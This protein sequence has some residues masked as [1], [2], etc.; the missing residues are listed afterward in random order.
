MEN[1]P[2]LAMTGTASQPVV[3]DILIEGE[4]KEEDDG[5]PLFLQ[6]VTEEKNLTFQLI[7]VL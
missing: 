4:I 6:V 5:A 3:R 1:H 7:N 2:I